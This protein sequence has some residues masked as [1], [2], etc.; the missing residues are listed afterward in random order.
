MKTKLL[1]LLFALVASVGTIMASV[2]VGGL[3]YDLNAAQS[4]AEVARIPNGLLSSIYISWREQK[5]RKIPSSITYNGK[6]YTVTSIGVYAFSGCSGMTSITIPNSVTSIGEQAFQDCSGLKSI[7]IPN[8]VTSIGTNAF[9][10]CTSL[11]V[12]GNIRYADTYLI[13]AVDKTL[14]SYTINKNTK[15]IGSYAFYECNKLTS[16]I[17]PDNVKNIGAGAFSQCTNLSTITIGE[18]VTNIEKYAFNE[19]TSLSSIAIADGVQNIE[20]C[21]F[22]GCSNLTHVTIG[23]GVTNIEDSYYDSYYKEYRYVFSGCS[24]ITS[25]T[26]NAKNCNRCAFGRCNKYW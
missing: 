15:W 2:E 4:T 7:T 14:S 25:V 6:T 1:T 12:V 22:Y 13:E 16:I 5:T 18:N 3:Y 20:R 9:V 11:P 23:K 21:A 10:N 8:S 24:N 17:I 26:W 19:C